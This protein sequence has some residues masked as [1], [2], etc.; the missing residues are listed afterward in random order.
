MISIDGSHGPPGAHALCSQRND[1]IDVMVKLQEEEKT[2]L[3]SLLFLML[4]ARDTMIGTRPILN[5]RLRTLV[6]FGIVCIKLVKKQTPM[7]AV[8]CLMPFF[9]ESNKRPLY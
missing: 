5:S 8:Y 6:M 2:V 9:P 7:A 1:D 4:F 3:C